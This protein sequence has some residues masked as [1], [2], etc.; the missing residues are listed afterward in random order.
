MS[1]GSSNNSYTPLV[2]L[3]LWALLG[4]SVGAFGC[5]TPHLTAKSFSYKQAV[6]PA[7]THIN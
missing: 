1:A 5:Q 6:T 7:L 3:N 2:S 4:S